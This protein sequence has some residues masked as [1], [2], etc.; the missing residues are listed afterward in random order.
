MT[1]IFS[2]FMAVKTCSKAISVPYLGHGKSPC[3]LDVAF[4]S[5]LEVDGAVSNFHRAYGAKL[6]ECAFCH[7]NI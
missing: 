6:L 7:G 2:L 5:V 1:A 3:F 4:L